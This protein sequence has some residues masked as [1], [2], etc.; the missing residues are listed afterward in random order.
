MLRWSV[1]F[2]LGA[3]KI[4]SP[5]DPVPSPQ[6]EEEEWDTQSLLGVLSAILSFFCTDE[7]VS[8]L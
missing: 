2:S 4:F 3:P 8:I 1:F 5:D 6:K 7:A